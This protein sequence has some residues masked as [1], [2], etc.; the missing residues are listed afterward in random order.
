[1]SPSRRPSVR[2]PIL[3]T[4]LLL[5]GALLAIPRHLPAGSSGE[6]SPYMPQGSTAGTPNGDYISDAGGLDTFYRYFI[7]VPPEQ[8]RLVIELFDADVGD[9][10]A[11]EDTDGRDRTRNVNFESVATYSLVHP[12]GAA[13]TTL[14]TTGNAAGPAGADDDWL[15]LFDSTAVDDYRDNFGAAAYN[16]SNGSLPWTTS[17]IETNDNNSAANGQMQITGGELRLGDNGGALSTIERQVDLSAFGGAIL[18]FDRRTTGVDAGDQFSVEVSP[19]GGAP[20]TLL[21]TWNGALANAGESYDISAFR[22]ANTRIRFIHVTGYGNNDFLFI[23]DFRI[24]D[25]QIAAGHWELRVDMAAG[26]DINALGI[27]AHDGNSGAGGTELNVYFDS[28]NQFGINPT[29][30]GAG[31]RSYDVFPYITAGCSAAKND[32]DFDS[33]NGTVGEMSFSSRTGAYSTQVFNTGVELSGNDVWLR[34]TFTGWTSDVNS[35]D[36]GIWSGEVS[37]STYNNQNGLNGNYTTFYMTNDLAAANPPAANPTPNAFR[38]YLPT[39]AGAAPLK[40]YLEQQLRHDS[41]PNPPDEDVPSD[42]TV[43]VRVVNPT[44]RAIT[45]S[46]A[47]LVTANVPNNGATVYAGAAQISQGMLVSQP[48]V[49]ATGPITW[50]PQT[51]AAGATALLSYEV[52]VTPSSGGQRVAATGTPASGGTQATYVDETGNTVQARARFTFGPLC[53][54]AVTE[55]LLTHAVVSSFR[56]FADERGGVRAEWTTASETA[57][58]GF[59]L[60]RWDGRRYVPVHKGLLPGLVH[61]AQGGTYRFHDEGAAPGQP[62][63]YLLEEVEADGKRRS[64]GPFAGMPGWERPEG[65]ERR[66]AYER[67]AHPTL[68]KTVSAGAAAADGKARSVT[69]FAAQDTGVHLSIRETGLYYVTREQVAAWLGMTVDKAEKAIAKGQ[70]SLTRGGQQVAF[71]PEPIEGSRRDLKDTPKMPRGFF[72]YGEAQPT[73]YSLDTVYRLQEGAGPVMQTRKVPRAAASSGTSFPDSKPFESDVI[74]ATAISP[75]PESDYWFW[76]FVISGDP[77]LGKRTF[78]FDAP[79]LAPSG[80]ATV[81]VSLH[82][83]TD[84]STPGEHVAVV[85]LNGTFLG[86]AQWQGITPHT[87]GFAVPASVLQET[88]NQLEI[89][90][91]VG[92]GA[93]FSFY[94]VDGFEVGYPRRFEAAADALAFT[95]G[96]NFQVTVTGFSDA[97]VRLF[98]VSNPLHPR[99]VAGA[100][101]DADPSGGFR[102][103]FV[104]SPLAHYLAVGPGALKTPLATRAWSTDEL[105][106]ASNRADVL[107]VVPAG[108]ESA[109]ERLADHRRGQG[110]EAAVASLDAVAD[111]FGHGTA[112]PHAVRSFLAHAAT[113]WTVRPR[114]VVLVGEGTLDYRNLQG[115]GDSVMP[116]LLIQAEGGLFPS[117]NRLGDV[118]GDGRPDLAV[119]RIPVLTA[120]ELDAYIDKIVAYESTGEPAWAANALMLADSP[121]AGASFPDDSDRIASQ[122]PAGYAVNRIY[123]GSETLAQ[124]RTRLFQGIADGA[125]LIDFVG[126]GGLDRLSADGLLTSDDVP[127]LTNGERLPVITAMTCTVNRFAVPGVPSLGELLVKSP[128]GGAAAVWGPSGLSFHGEARQLAGTFYRQVSGPQGVPQDGRLGDWIL[129]SMN[130]FRARGGDGAM[131]DIYNLLGD[132]SLVVRRGPAPAPSGGSGSE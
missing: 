46:G 61:A 40:P 70:I 7:E 39:D 34:D 18:T 11:T 1:M 52:R 55:G 45:F 107:I 103:S 90:G 63:A 102:A 86:E 99:W 16:N 117:D 111:L 84:N 43:T 19:T 9:G 122:L 119:G 79:A 10:G 112:T 62:Q 109:A 30:V 29:N 83:A 129:Q 108:M 8:T 57:T 13:R 66:A 35:T 77:D 64:H 76:D 17:W 26:D 94:F 105:L 132:P 44:S 85:T 116:P 12:T 38:V 53:E 22:T 2:R 118:N 14:F 93:P 3:G 91:A 4:A 51:V 65:P 41:G 125:S 110:L 71:F 60:L 49:G 27:R 124:A 47:N 24:R 106:D 120:A 114:Y 73:L 74:P 88:G 113:A 75:D 20:W 104:P 56:T 80:D 69:A 89:L 126:H 115:F 42:Y 121:D 78:T 36:Y 81:L 72:F 92:N 97:T 101:V 127:S 32:F 68:R 25:T 100:A 58:A 37:I 87:A 130:D 6:T 98:D 28:F 59:R 33:N 15:S 131:L 82:G 31:T 54:L 128:A 96:G 23:D 50:N 21:E 67:E 5:G 48:A 95:G 123:L